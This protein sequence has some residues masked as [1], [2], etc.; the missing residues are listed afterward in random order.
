MTSLTNGQHT[1]LDT[2]EQLAE[3]WGMSS[4]NA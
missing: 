3:R 1:V 2:Y 4:S